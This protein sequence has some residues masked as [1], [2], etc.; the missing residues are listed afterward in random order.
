MI[1]S[2]SNTLRHTLFGVLCAASITFGSVQAFA[3]PQARVFIGVACDP[4]GDDHGLDFCGGTCYEAG[5]SYGFCTLGGQ[6][7]C[8]RLRPGAS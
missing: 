1:H 3:A 5:Y 4:Y 7:D 8:R 6:C 2:I